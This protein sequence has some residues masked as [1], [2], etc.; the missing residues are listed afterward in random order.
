MHGAFHANHAADNADVVI[1]I[2]MRFDDRAMGRFSDFNPGAKIIHIDIDPAE[3]GKNFKTE[4]P[5]VGDAKAVLEELIEAIQPNTHLDWMHWIDDLR[6]EHPSFEVPESPEMSSQYVI[7][8][9]YEATKG[10]AIVVTGVG[11]H[12]M[13]TGQHYRMTKPRQLISSGGLGTMGY[14]VPAA[15]GAQMACPDEVVWSI[16]GDGGFQMNMQELATIVDC[17]APVK[18][19]ILN[20]GFLGM[21]R[22][23]QELFYANNYVAVDLKEE[24]TQPDFLKIAEAYGIKAIRITAKEDVRDAIE[25]AN[26]Y[27]GPVLL[28]FHVI[29]EENVWPMVPAGASLAETI[30]DPAKNRVPVAGD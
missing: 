19:A 20:N 6:R 8:Q 10:D 24:I 22:Q 30:E 11:Q 28:D 5:I 15:L 7:N 14:E 1:G 29:K 25:Q 17:R 2:G 21:V 23:W 27:P 9:I 16:C 12:Q 3:I 18:M 13:W 4:V 26:A